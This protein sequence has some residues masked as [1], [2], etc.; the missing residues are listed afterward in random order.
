MNVNFW[1]AQWKSWQ[2]TI[3]KFLKFHYQQ[4][5]ISPLQKFFIFNL[6]QKWDLKWSSLKQTHLA[7]LP[8]RSKSSSG[9]QERLSRSSNSSFI[10]VKRCTVISDFSST[11]CLHSAEVQWNKWSIPFGWPN[12]IK[13]S[14]W[15]SLVSIWTLPGIRFPHHSCQHKCTP[16]AFPSQCS[17]Q[18]CQREGDSGAVA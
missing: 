13:Y 6:F 12:F 9:A 11:T 10:T 16:P 15:N 18:G 1:V 7:S 3:F 17:L 5:I 14:P 4:K 2:T 8:G